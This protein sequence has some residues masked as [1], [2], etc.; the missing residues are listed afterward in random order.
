MKE[1]ASAGEI[2]PDLKTQTYGYLEGQAFGNSV[3]LVIFR[4]SLDFS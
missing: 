4:L 3:L 2:C 1:K